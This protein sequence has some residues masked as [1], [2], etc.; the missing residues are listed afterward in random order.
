[1][2]ASGC[3]R[4]FRHFGTPERPIICWIAT[5]IAAALRL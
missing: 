4:R 5:R 3:A 2:I 1:M